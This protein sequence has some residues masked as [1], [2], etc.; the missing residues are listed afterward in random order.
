MIVP[1]GVPGTAGFRPPRRRLPWGRKVLALL[2]AAAVGSTVT[3]VAMRNDR[4]A[5]TPS[6]HQTA[7]PSS[8]PAAPQFSSAEADAAKQN[9]CQQFDLSVRG[10][11]GQGGLRVE[12]NLNEPVVLRALNSATAVQNALVPAVPTDVAS[13]ARKYVITTLDTT[14]AVMGNTPASEG[15]QLTDARNDAINGLLDACGLPR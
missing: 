9:L 15:N 11:E 3:Y 4:A 14:T 5:S 2:L 13:A 12:G 7:S 8:V 6:S 10:Q 1:P